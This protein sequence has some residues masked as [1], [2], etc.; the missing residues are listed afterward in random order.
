MRT[1]LRVYAAYVLVVGILLLFPAWASAVFARPI[2]DAAVT[3]GWG[4]SLIVLALLAYVAST[5]VAK[6]GGLAWVFVAGLLLSAA[7]LVYF[8]ATGVYAARTAL[9][10]VVINIALAAW[11]WTSRSK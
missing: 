8:W 11:I 9:V 10:P 1:A 4:S 2:M 3:S 6:Y 5:D 7:D